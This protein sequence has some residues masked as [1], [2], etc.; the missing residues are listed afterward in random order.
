M[1]VLPDGL[2]KNAAAQNTLTTTLFLLVYGTIHMSLLYCPLYVV[3]A[4]HQRQ[5][6]HEASS[7]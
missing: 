7:E 4:N 2:G 3:Q 1:T 6:F 5:T